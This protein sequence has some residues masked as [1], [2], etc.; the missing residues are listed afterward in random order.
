MHRRLLTPRIMPKPNEVADKP[1]LRP[2]P[3]TGAETGVKQQAN[4][5][6][7]RLRNVS[8]AEVFRLCVGKI[9]GVKRATSNSALLWGH[10]E[11]Q[12]FVA[13]GRKTNGW[14]FGLFL[15]R[16][17]QPRRLSLGL[18]VGPQLLIRPGEGATHSAPPLPP[19][20]R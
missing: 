18:V 6:D 14:N 10:A 11:N 20:G 2:Q 12:D 4:I 3:V 15:S 9:G 7:Y 8:P 17:K 19:R 5:R 1:S 13:H 16:F